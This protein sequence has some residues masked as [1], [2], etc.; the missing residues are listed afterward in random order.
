VILPDAGVE[1]GFRR[2]EHLREA[3]RQLAITYRGRSVGSP[4]FSGGLALFP[5]HGDTVEDLLRAADAALYQAKSA[6]RD[7]LVVADS[8]VLP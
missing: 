5:K 2:I 3:T 8:F 4:S 1:D 6:G 7:R